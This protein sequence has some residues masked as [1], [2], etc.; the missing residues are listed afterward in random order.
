MTPNQ[1]LAIGLMVAVGICALVTAA[2]L[3]SEARLRHL[4]TRTLSVASGVTADY[5]TLNLS[6]IS[7]LLHAL[8]ERIGN[9]RLYSQKDLAGLES[10]IA[11]SGLN[12]RRVL[13]MVLGGKV[14][15]MGLIPASAIIYGYIAAPGL[16]IRILIIAISVVV[17]MLG[18]DW[19]LSAIRRPH[20]AALQRGVID[21]LDLLVVCSEAGLGLE[22]ALEQVAREM[23]HSNRPTAAALTGLRDEIRVLPDRRVAF[24]N[25]AKR[26][27]VDG[28]Q[29]M[30]TTLAQS[31]QYGTPL[32][33]ALR[34][35]ADQLR[36]ERMIKL[37]ERAVKLPAKLVL[38][39][40]LFIMPCL[41]IILV[42]SSFM[43]L[44]DVLPTLA[45]H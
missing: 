31:M 27:G 38:P 8:G 19:V 18:P 25:F 26:T 36:H 13:P 14:I 7:G 9:M 6:W 39:L 1:W 28:M 33:Q 16:S 44:Y 35:A 43:R 20:V 24:A 5:R 22:S 2:L 21:A 37:E 15:L 42:G 34:A 32:G 40:I 23:Q 11:T 45:H 4:E 17:G 41:F 10:M 30:A 12:P 29:R 3:L